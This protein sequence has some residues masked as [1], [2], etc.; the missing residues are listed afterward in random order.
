[1]SNSKSEIS[2]D[3]IDVL[4]LIKVIWDNKKIITVITALAAFFSVIYSLAQPNIYRGDA[5]LAPAEEKSGG[6]A[7]LA[8]QFG[9]VASL[10]GIPLPDESADKSDLGLEV[11]KSRK[12]AREFV[13]RHKILPQLM[14][15]GYWIKYKRRFYYKNMTIRQKNG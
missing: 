4:E 9:G 3:E 8:S 7:G 12:F 5:L 2:D 1:M 13:E 11:L 10:A 6:M 15:V 14:A